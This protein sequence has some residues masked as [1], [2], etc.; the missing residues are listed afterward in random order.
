[1]TTTSTPP[2]GLIGLTQISGPVGRFI[3]FGQWI[4]GDGFKDWEHA[5]VSLGNGQIVQ[6]EPGGATIVP[7]T[8]YSSIYWC[9]GIYK[10]ATPAEAALIAAAARKYA[11]PGPWGDHGVPYSFLDY[12]WLADHRLRIPVPGIQKYIANNNHMICSQLADRCYQDASV[13]VFTDSR[14][15]GDVTPLSLYNRDRQLLDQLFPL[16]S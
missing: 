6:A 3:E 5:F 14:W 16:A 7:V 15:N 10:L 12:L 8:T 1:V 4:N 13:H 11:S 2:P 9:E